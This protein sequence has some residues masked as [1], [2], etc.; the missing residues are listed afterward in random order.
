MNGL[1]SL[2]DGVLWALEFVGIVTFAASGALVAIRRGFDL[3]GLLALGSITALGGG[4]VRDLVIADGVPVAFGD[5]V[6][7]ATALVAALA[8]VGAQRVLG[9]W[10]RTMLTCDAAGLALFSVSGTAIALDAGLDGFAATLLGVVTA[11]GGGVIRDVLAGEP[12]LIFRSDSTLYAIPASLGA[13]STALWH[14]AGVTGA[15][16][17]ISSAVAVFVLRVSA[18]RFGWRAP[19]PGR[20]DDRPGPVGGRQ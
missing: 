4:I 11:V 9:R 6:Y 16:T 3:V 14:A 2:D 17:G 10:R 13:A 12:P 7:I 1:G 5:P 8:T 20:S 18:L 19:S 15:A